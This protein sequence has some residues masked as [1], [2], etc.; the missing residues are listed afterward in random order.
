MP[1]PLVV[2][3]AQI[4]CTFGVAPSV[5]VVVPEGLP[6]TAGELPI[7]TMLD[8]VPIE[9]IEPFGMCSSIANPEV[10]AATTAAAGV[11]TPMPCVPVVPDPW[12]PCS[13]NVLVNEQ[14]VLTQ[15]SRC[16]CVW[17]GVISII[18]PNQAQV[19]TE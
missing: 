11:L 6:V 3:G 1:F 9:N 15:M 8:I 5:L 17:G 14:P 13:E 2:E 7:A 12:E 18:G 16:E 4:E 10:A 19:L